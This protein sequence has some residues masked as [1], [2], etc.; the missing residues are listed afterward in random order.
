[1]TKALILFDVDGTLTKSRLT[2]K[3]PMI[4]MI[5]RLRDL[6]DIDIGIVGGS[7]LVKQREQ[8]G[9]ENDDLVI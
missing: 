2:I 7:N 1:M 9:D 4:D 6:K 8:L 5:H 3:K